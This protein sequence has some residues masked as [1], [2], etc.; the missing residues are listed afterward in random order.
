MIR[1]RKRNLSDR[2]PQSTSSG[3]W[4]LAVTRRQMPPK[5]LSQNWHD[6]VASRLA[7]WGFYGVMQL[8]LRTGIVKFGGVLTKG[9]P[10]L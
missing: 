6:Y 5:A 8:W 4:G 7:S 3:S 1:V 9:S 2:S 10:C